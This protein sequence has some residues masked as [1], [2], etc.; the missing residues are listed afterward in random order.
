MPG[1]TDCPVS[2]KQETGSVNLRDE[3]RWSGARNVHLGTQL[4]VLWN[5]EVGDSV[6]IYSIL[7]YVLIYKRMGV[8]EMRAGR[9]VWKRYPPRVQ[10]AGESLLFLPESEW[11]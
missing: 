5:V 7:S 6:E 1:S 3:I 8:W 10:I 2:F 4:D 11:G 9:G